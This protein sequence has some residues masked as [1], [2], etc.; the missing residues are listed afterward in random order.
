MPLSK[1]YSIYLFESFTLYLSIEKVFNIM[2]TQN[3]HLSESR[4]DYDRL[5]LSI[6]YIS[7]ALSEFPPPVFR[8]ASSIP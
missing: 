1:L 3:H 8:N 7:G 2:I 5:I 4:T 6:V